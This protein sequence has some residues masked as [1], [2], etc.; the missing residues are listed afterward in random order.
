MNGQRIIAILIILASSLLSAHVLGDKAYPGILC[1][2]GL[3]GLERKFTWNIRPERR[4]IRLFLLLALLVVFGLHY[5]FALVPTHGYAEP[6]AVLAWETVTRYFLACMILMLYLGTPHRLPLSL[7]LFFLAITICAGQLL[8][9]EDPLNSKVFRPL[10]LL[11]VACVILFIAAPGDAGT[12]QRVNVVGGGS[13]RLL[14]VTVFLVTLNVGWIVGSL[15]YRFQGQLNYLGM[16]LLGSE[17]KLIQSGAQT[18]AIGFSN[19]GQLSSLALMKTDQDL[20]P[21]LK[22]KSASQPEYLR[23]KAFETYG[24]SAWKDLSFEEAIFSKGTRLGLAL[25]GMVGLYQMKPSFSVEPR[26]MKIEHLMDMGQTMFTPLTACQV[27]VAGSTLM[28]NDNNLVYNP[29]QRGRF[30]YRVFYDRQPYRDPPQPSQ[31]RRMLRVPPD[32]ESAIRPMA[33]RVFA[34]CRTTAQKIEAVIAHFR[35][36]YDYSLDISPPADGDKLTYFLLNETSGYCEY[37]ASGAAILLRLENVPTRY[38]TGFYVT[39][40]ELSSNTW[41]A[42]NINAHAWVEAW[43]GERRRWETVEATVQADLAVSSLLDSAGGS[44]QGR[45]WYQQLLQSVSL[46]GVPG[47]FIWLYDFGGPIV[48]A[49]MVLAFALIVLYPILRFAQK[50]WRAYRVRRS[51]DTMT[52]EQRRLKRLLRKMD[53]RLRS[54][55]LKRE[56]QETTNAFSRRL[57]TYEQTRAARWYDRYGALRFRAH[58]TAD[59]IGSLRQAIP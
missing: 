15:L 4:I 50:S 29:S 26:E 42:R 46:Y 31:W 33:E 1:I 22:I 51:T 47:L 43:D 5:R 55:G 32:L 28:L 12:R 36:N 16:R 7:G 6:A 24:N 10:E 48:N 40:R 52:R 41:I 9:L 27:E 13:R 45:F 23:A 14:F 20:N 18:A 49:A 19:S 53:L 2:L 3:L 38:V 34:D 44:G 56:P 17:A 59:Q 8:L 21:I 30:A 39:D 37:F 25:G 35:D 54:R 11:A 57:K 58:L